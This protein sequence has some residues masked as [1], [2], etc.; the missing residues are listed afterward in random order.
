MCWN[1]LYLLAI[2][3]HEKVKGRIFSYL[4]YKYSQSRENATNSLIVY[5]FYTWL[6][7]EI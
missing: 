2:L 1:K 3:I 7:L 6:D 4:Y 5:K